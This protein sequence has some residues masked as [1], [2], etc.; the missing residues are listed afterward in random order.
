MAPSLSHRIASHRN[1]IAKYREDHKKNSNPL[2]GVL[3]KGRKE[4]NQ[5]PLSRG[6]Q[7]GDPR[8]TVLFEVLIASYDTSRLI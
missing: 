2:L 6:L 4:F 1:R 5:R 7:I 8:C 3:E